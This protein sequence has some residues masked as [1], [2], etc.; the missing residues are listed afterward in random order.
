MSSTTSD[1]YGDQSSIS[2]KSSKSQDSM[3]SVARSQKAGRPVDPTIQT[4]DS[5]D[6]SHSSIEADVERLHKGS[7]HLVSPTFQ[8]GIEAD[9][10]RQHKGA[11]HPV[12]PMYQPSIEAVNV[13]RPH[14][15]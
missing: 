1:S 9:L 12:S 14:K 8:P 2:S 5:V 15:V 6:F 7:G 11:G 13:V 10:E 3:V 4:S